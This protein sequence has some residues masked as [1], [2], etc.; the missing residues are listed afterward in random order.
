MVENT[1]N[2]YRTNQAVTVCIMIIAVA[3]AIL[4][5]GYLGFS[6]VVAAGV[7]LVL[8]GLAVAGAAH[9]HSDAPDKF[10]PAESTYRLVIGAV[11]AL[12]GA[13]VA[14]VGLGVDY[15]LLIV[16]LLIGI[17]LIG[18]GATY[19]GKKTSKY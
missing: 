17:A 12:V 6:W 1:G 15:V 3:V 5:A 10:G 13:V 2:P 16:V 9:M 14:L 8:A 18:L 4:M 19:I 7:F 11:I